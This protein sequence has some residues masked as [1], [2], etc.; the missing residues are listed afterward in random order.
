MTERERLIEL[1]DQ[2]CGYVEEQP[3]EKLADYLIKNGVY[4]TG[5]ETEVKP[6]HD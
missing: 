1:L 5:Y 2:N 4:I 6:K 3:A